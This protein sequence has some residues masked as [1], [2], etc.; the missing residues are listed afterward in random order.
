MLNFQSVLKKGIPLLFYEAAASFIAGV[1]FSHASMGQIS[2]PLHVALASVMSPTGAI[3]ILAGSSVSYVV[4]SSVMNNMHMLIALFIISVLKILGNEKLHPSFCALI[5]GGSLL[6]GGIFSAAF[7]HVSVY[8]LLSYLISS[9]LAAVSAYFINFIYYNYRQQKK[10]VLNS[11]AMCAYSVIYILFISALVNVNF[12]Y[13]NAG[14]IAAV[15]ITLLAADKYRHTGGVICG[16]LA[17]CGGIL[18]NFDYGIPMIFLPVAGFLTGFMHRYSRVTFSV[19]F[20]II[21]LFAQLALLDSSF[22]FSYFIDLIISCFLYI[23][24]RGI[25]LER[26]I[27]S[28]RDSN[29]TL[30]EIFGYKLRMLSGTLGNIRKD[31]EEVSQK[32]KKNEEN[33]HILLKISKGVCSGCQNKAMCWSEEYENTRKGINE[34]YRNNIQS[35]CDI[36]DI[37]CGCINPQELIRAVNNEKQNHQS[38]QIHS[39]ELEENRH[40]LFEQ[41]KA[42]ENIIKSAEKK[43]TVNYSSE[44]TDIVCM[45]L[46]KEKCGYSK[47]WAY[48]NDINILSIEIYA[49][50]SG[51]FASIDVI[52]RMLSSSLHVRLF[53][54]QIIPTGHRDEVVCYLHEAPEYELE[55]YSIVRGSE[56]GNYICGDTVDIFFDGRGSQYIIVADGMGSGNSAAL[57]SKMAVSLF[58]KMVRGGSSYDGAIRMVN[59]LMLTKSDDEN[60]TTFDMAK[61]DLYSC[62]M[63]LM[64]SGAASTLLMQGDTVRRIGSQTFPLGISSDVDIFRKKYKL[65]EGDIVVMLSDGVNEN[66]YKFIKQL[67]LQEESVEKIVTEIYEKSSIFNGGEQKDDVSVVAAKIRKSV[68]EM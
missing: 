33:S 24:M 36:P 68:R 44:I 66:E 4:S 8:H 60:F 18:C 52:K 34:I 67:L 23:L 47:V 29:E 58:K 35:E 19:Y 37:I 54:H 46:D 15:T 40:I 17:A 65:R 31:T 41:I 20:I 22:C 30:S 3:S 61:I 21:N 38:E 49:P 59:G 11:S 57:E 28:R 1:V 56:R 16:S 12:T 26:W 7:L 42:T 27:V 63:I 2:S 9:F 14:R 10:I 32:L 48:Y 43:F 5:S 39:A 64:K 55:T 53:S 13:F 51:A 45:I 50:D 25:C 6:A 62:E